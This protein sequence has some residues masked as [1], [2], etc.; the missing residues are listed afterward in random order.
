MLIN[1]FRT[2]YFTQ[3]FVLI[4][5]SILLWMG[6]FMHP[7]SMPVEPDISTPIY[8]LVYSWL[9][10]F[11]FPTTLIAFTL[12]LFSALLLNYILIINQVMPKNSLISALIF[13]VLMSSDRY[14]LTLHPVLISMPIMIFVVHIILDAHDKQDLTRSS[15]SLGILI[16]LA[17]MIYFPAIFLIPVIWLAYMVYSIASFKE[18]IITLIGFT[19][20][21]LYVFTWYFISDSFPDVLL[22]YQLNF[23]RIFQTLMV[24]DIFQII[25][26]SGIVVLLIMP[27]MTRV[28]TSLNTLTISMRKKISVI[29]WFTLLSIVMI[30]VSGNIEFNI[31][32]YLCGSTFISFYF[33]ITKKS[34][35]NELVFTALLIGIA[36]NNFLNM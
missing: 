36:V 15:L 20:P 2:S 12:L 33:A 3:Y 16:S 21:Y 34:A 5:I 10:N 22:A 6:G 32:I 7:V 27:S 23:N 26:W 29:A 28:L 24:Y 31:V 30:F 4:I 14:L 8:N 18:W 11:P 25:I 1:F 35:W 19:I 9:H 13:I 17:S